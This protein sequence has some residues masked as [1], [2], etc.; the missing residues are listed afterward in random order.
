M[1]VCE[2]A[3]LTNKGDG[4]DGGPSVDDCIVMTLYGHDETHSDHHLTVSDVV[5]QLTDGKQSFKYA[6]VKEGIQRLIDDG[7]VEQR[8]GK[9]REGTQKSRL[10]T[11]DVLYLIKERVVEEQL[12]TRTEIV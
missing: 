12:A 5:G 7:I 8:P 1:S 2:A 4:D 11:R 10:V 3:S 9:H 6:E